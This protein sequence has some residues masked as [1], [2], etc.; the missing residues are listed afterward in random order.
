MDLPDGL[1]IWL[2]LVPAI[3]LEPCLA[4]AALLLFPFDCLLFFVGFRL[5]MVATLC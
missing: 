5:L 1:V 2:A 4:A 3:P